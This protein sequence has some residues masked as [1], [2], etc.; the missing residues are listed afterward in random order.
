MIGIKSSLDDEQK[1]FVLYLGIWFEI[2]I[3]AWS[4]CKEQILKWY[5]TVLIDVDAGSIY[6]D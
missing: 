4:G 2:D 1:G 5:K 3:V 6:G